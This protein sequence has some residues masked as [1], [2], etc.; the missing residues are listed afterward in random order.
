MN[1]ENINV[2]NVADGNEAPAIGAG[3]FVGGYRGD[4]GVP[5]YGGAAFGAGYGG[6]GLYGAGMFGN[7]FAGAGLNMMQG[8][9]GMGNAGM[10]MAGM[11]MNMM[12][13]QAMMGLRG[14]AQL[15][16]GN[17]FGNPGQFGFPNGGN[18]VM[19]AFPNGGNMAMGA[20]PNG[21]NM[22]MGHAI[23]MNAY[24]GYGPNPGPGTGGMDTDG[25]QYTPSGQFM[26][27]GRYH[28]SALFD[29]LWF[30]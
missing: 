13:P 28:N 5:G 15:G 11:G 6:G 23:G 18:M 17:G 19:G 12:G 1:N 16:I 30:Y 27:W 21:G 29:S 26:P 24:V 14:P 4:E 10:G 2:E 9:M 20:F 8:N 7:A 25:N 3:G 22:A